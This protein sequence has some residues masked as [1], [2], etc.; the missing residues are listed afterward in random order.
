MVISQKLLNPGEEI[1]VSTRTHAKALLLPLLTLVVLLAV[2]V[3]GA[4]LHRQ[5]HRDVAGDLGGG[6]G[7][8]PVAGRVAHPRLA[9]GVVHDH[10]P[11]ADHAPRHPDPR[12][13]RHPARPDQR[14]RLRARPDRPDA[15]LR[16]AGHQRRQHQRPGAH[17]RHPAR[18][19]DPARPQPAAAPAAR[20]RDP[21][22]RRGTDHRRPR[23]GPA[24]GRRRGLGRPRP[25][26]SRRSCARTPSYSASQVARETRAS[27]WARRAGCG[28]RS[29]S[30]RPR[31]RRSTPRPTSRRSTR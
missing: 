27:R 9:A 16:H 23:R 18:R 19:G 31:G 20:W 7:A 22:A 25:G 4:G 17:L 3:A 26:S 28:A 14:R 10:Q 11:A 8:G 24:R 6:R 12:G 2:G 30:R 29:A 13:P 1:I 15:R 5:R 21:P